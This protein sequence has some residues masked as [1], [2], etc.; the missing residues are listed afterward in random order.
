MKAK[1]TIRKMT[2]LARKAA[3][4]ARAIHGLQR[5]VDYFTE[6]VQEVELERNAAVKALDSLTEAH[7]LLKEQF[8]E[9]L[10]RANA[11]ENNLGHPCSASEVESG[12]RH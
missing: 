5:R 3:Y 4:L 7:R 1:R 10:E 9:T 6:A 12:Q 2:P 8:E 11:Y